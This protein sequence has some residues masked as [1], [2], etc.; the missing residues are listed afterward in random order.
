MDLIS[1][2]MLSVLKKILILYW[3]QQT[4]YKTKLTTELWSYID[5]AFIFISFLSEIA[6]L[7]ALEAWFCDCAKM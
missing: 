3:V 4:G 2:N 7:F 5:Y 1:Q 6:E